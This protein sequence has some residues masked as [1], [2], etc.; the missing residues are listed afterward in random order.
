MEIFVGEVP[1]PGEAPVDRT[2]GD[3][4][5]AVLT[6]AETEPDGGRVGGEDR[7]S[8]PVPG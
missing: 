3:S 7:K 6:A 1:A 5:A 2:R 8:I 4:Q